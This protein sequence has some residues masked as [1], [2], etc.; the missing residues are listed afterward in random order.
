MLKVE[1]DCP[2]LS[3]LTGRGTEDP[4]IMYENIICGVGFYG[5][6]QLGLLMLTEGEAD[7]ESALWNPRHLFWDSLLD[8]QFFL[9]L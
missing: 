9:N 2:R 1:T 3:G 5:L 4:C 8:T 7:Y 6:R